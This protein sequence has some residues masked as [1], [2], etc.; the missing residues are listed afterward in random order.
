LSIPKKPEGPSREEGEEVEETYSG[1]KVEMNLGKEGP[2]P[3][4]TAKGC[5][6]K[7]RET[8]AFILRV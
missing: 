3:K 1:T 5:I 8:A 2:P 7:K 4:W 6:P